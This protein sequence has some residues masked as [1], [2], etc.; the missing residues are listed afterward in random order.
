MEVSVRIKGSNLK[1]IYM[2][3]ERDID[4]IIGK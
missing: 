3:E 1:I 2:T 4:R